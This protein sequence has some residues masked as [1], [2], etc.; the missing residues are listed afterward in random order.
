MAKHVTVIKLTLFATLLTLSD[1]G[2][3]R[4]SDTICYWSDEAA[5]TAADDDLIRVGT[6]TDPCGPNRSDEAAS[7][8]AD[9]DLLF[10]FYW[11]V[12]PSS[13]LLSING[14][15][16]WFP[17]RKEFFMAHIVKMVSSRFALYFLISYGS[18]RCPFVAGITAWSKTNFW[19]R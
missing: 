10:V 3:T 12:Q 18:T 16:C 5:S 19:R 1:I 8:V 13:S 7:T 6:C 11:Q 4:Q 2:P 17:G 15:Y 9:D 14:V